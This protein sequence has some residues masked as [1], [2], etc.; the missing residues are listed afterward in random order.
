[1][2]QWMNDWLREIIVIIMLAVFIDLLLPNDKMQRYVK[3]VLSLFILMAIL[4]PI[5]SL[6]KA[7]LSFDGWRDEWA[8][9]GS[10]VGHYRSLDDVLLAGE[11]F[12]K[13]QERHTLSA[14]EAHV[15]AQIK[16]D[17][18]RELPGYEYGVMV[19]TRIDEE[20]VVIDQVRI[21]VMEEKADAIGQTMRPI[22][23]V[24]IN[25]E[26]DH[27]NEEHVLSEDKAQANA[28]QNEHRSQIHHL[29][30]QHWQVAA[31]QTIIHYAEDIS[32]LHGGEVKQWANGYKSLSNG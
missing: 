21:D 14:I 10:D 25:I 8:D 30:N 31:N 24:V 5:V 4:S 23:T 12:R 29:L 27:I 22:E 18:Q 32:G 13:L 19:V 17:L 11:Q 20:Q 1:M 16:N 2:L 9:S 3:V 26:I 6:L 15:A 7:D 28:W